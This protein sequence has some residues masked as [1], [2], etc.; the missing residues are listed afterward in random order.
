MRA[1]DN[2]QPIK[3]NTNKSVRDT[4]TQHGRPEEAAHGADAGV[5]DGDDE[6]QALGAEKGKNTND[7]DKEIKDGEDG[8]GHYHLA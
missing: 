3:P 2:A 1:T 4:R 7:T 5:D 8:G 6:Q